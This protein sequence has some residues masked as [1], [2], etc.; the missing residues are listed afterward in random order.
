M[1]DLE[2]IIDDIGFPM[3][4]KPS[5]SYA[6][7]NISMSSVVHTPAQ[8]LEQI[9]KS[10]SASNPDVVAPDRMELS[11]EKERE[12]KEHKN[13]VIGKASLNEKNMGIGIETPTVFV[14]RFL[15]GREFTVLVVGDKDWGIKVFPVAERAFDPKLGKFERILAF[16]K[17][18]EGYDLEGGHGK[19]DDEELCK[20]QMANEAWQ[21]QLQEVAKN[22]Y[23]ALR[24]N[25][26]GRVDI[27]TLDM[28]NCEPVVLEVNANCGLS[29]EKDSSSMA[30]ILIMSDIAPPAFV[31]D[32]VDHALHR[33]RVLYEFLNSDFASQQSNSNL[34]FNSNVDN[35][36]GLLERLSSSLIHEAT[37]AM[38]PE[39][40]ARSIE[41]C[42]ALTSEFQHSR[43]YIHG[44]QEEFLVEN[45]LDKLEAVS[46]GAALALTRLE[47]DLHHFDKLA[48]SYTEL[49][50]K[51][52]FLGFIAEEIP[53]NITLESNQKMEANAA[54]AK[55]VEEETDMSV[56]QL[57]SQINETAE[58]ACKEYD[59][60]HQGILELTKALKDIQ[61]MERELAEM[62][63]MDDQYRGM[64]L[65]HSQKVLAAQTQQL[66]QLHQ[67][68][69]EATAEIEELKWQESKLKDSNQ[70][71]D[72]QCIKVESQAKDAIKMSSLRRPE[73][74][75]AYKECL[76]ATRQYQ[77]GVGLESIQ[78]L[79]DSNSLILEYK[80]V[81][82][83]A[84][85]H[86]INSAGKTSSA[87]NT[88]NRKP[89][90]TQF[91]IK[92]HPK[93][94]RLLTAN[95][96]NAGCDVKDVIQIA[97]ARNDISFLVAETLDRVMKAHP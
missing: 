36:Q 19:E 43:L 13:G 14:E 2:N 62:K 57:Q 91:L 26:Y 61:N 77:E 73:I 30:N 89:I 70:L 68:I 67:D 76:E 52:R 45:K 48:I 11:Q 87:R 66:Y 5:I 42:G 21:D 71:L 51:E 58:I 8:L 79:A 53:L 94:G 60:L 20:Y 80:I 38:D 85:I 55:K 69:D 32:L 39:S 9:N 81:P 54:S 40:T 15:A 31:R 16:D 56:I 29:F 78:Y 90:L 17:Y 24:G 34:A 18:W 93:S 10:L 82:G 92:V 64:T 74:E 41:L 33:S 63:K 25:G 1:T 49:A 72:I 37:F 6:S 44:L 4:V 50:T 47:G 95:I 27:R 12:Q 84:A 23:L 59:D 35:T 83:S 46:G 7:I 3:I 65:E 28:D 97:K 96:E 86:T 75:N 22:A 88:R